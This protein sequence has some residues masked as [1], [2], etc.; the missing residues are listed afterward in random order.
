MEPFE[1]YL[2]PFDQGDPMAGGQRRRRLGAD[3]AGAEHRHPRP[4]RARMAAAARGPRAESYRRETRYR[5]GEAAPGA[6]RSPPPAAPNM[7]RS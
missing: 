6:G 5:R 3:Q 1:G 7:F 2:R 4:G